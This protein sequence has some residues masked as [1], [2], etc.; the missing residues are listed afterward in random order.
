MIKFSDEVD[1]DLFDLSK[2]LSL[3]K[4][5]LL[6]IFSIN[7]SESN[8]INCIKIQSPSIINY[9]EIGNVSLYKYLNNINT[10]EFKELNKNSL[11][12][13]RYGDYGDLKRLFT[14]INNC[15]VNIARGSSQKS[16]VIS[17]L[18]IRFSY[19]LM[20]I[21]NFNYKY[22]SYLN[23]FDSITKDKYLPSYRYK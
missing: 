6:N 11:Y 23:T 8:D 4:M 21:S 7:F 14:G 13:L 10:L 15:A 16:H 9:I 5:D 2:K 20:A 17:S 19:Y 22:T 3:I 12:I 18:E 1:V